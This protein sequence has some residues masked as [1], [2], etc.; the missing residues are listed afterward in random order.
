MANQISGSIN[1]TFATI[2]DW[3][4]YIVMMTKKFESSKLKNII[5]FNNYISTIKISKKEIPI[6]LYNAY[7]DYKYSIY[8]N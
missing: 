1:K 5:I 8:A 2:L 7:G 6:D 3:F 4:S